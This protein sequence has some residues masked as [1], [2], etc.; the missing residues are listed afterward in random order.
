MAEHSVS[1]RE[2][3]RFEETVLPHL[4]AAFNLARWLTRNEHD[5]EDVVQESYLRAL[6]SFRSFHLGRDGRAWL[7]KIVRNTCYT[8]LRK[9]RPHEVTTQF[10]EGARDAPTAGS[11]PETDLIAKANTE[12][13]RAALEHLSLEHRELLILRELEG[14]SY[15]EIAEIIDIPLGTVMSRLSR[16]RKELQDRLLEGAQEIRR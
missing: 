16:A 7:L 8:W 11:D 13:V 1:N 14:F 2:V 3:E 10:D 9:N 5:A 4:N 6:R 15:K 12:F